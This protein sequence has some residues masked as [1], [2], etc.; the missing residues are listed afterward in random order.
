MIA[1]EFKS[2]CSVKVMLKNLFSIAKVCIYITYST[3]DDIKYGI[4]NQSG[5][6]LML[7]YI[8]QQTSYI[9]NNLTTNDL[10]VFPFI[11][12]TYRNMLI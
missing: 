12:L 11:N 7:N 9:F 2:Y 8:V 5:S 10:M 1:L 6:F 3:Y 4:K